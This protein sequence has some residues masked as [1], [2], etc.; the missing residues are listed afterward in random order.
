MKQNNKYKKSLNDLEED[1][2]KI[3]ANG[4]LQGGSGESAW[5]VNNLANSDLE[6]KAL[7]KVIL[8]LDTLNEEEKVKMNTLIGSNI[9]LARILIKDHVDEWREK[10]LVD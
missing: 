3:L 4:L 8:E 2:S 9:N 7:K 10:N 1:L 5:V 6:K